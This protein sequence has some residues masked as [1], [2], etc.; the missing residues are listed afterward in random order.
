[1]LFKGINDA[2]IVDLIKNLKIKDI[3]I[4]EI[5][6]TLLAKFVVKMDTTIVIGDLTYKFNPPT[7]GQIVP[8]KFTKDAYGE[9]EVDKA[10]FIDLK[11][12]V[13]EETTIAVTTK[14]KTNTGSAMLVV[15]VTDD[16]G[17]IVGN[18]TIELEESQVKVSIENGKIMLNTQEV[19]VLEANTIITSGDA[20][21]TY[22]IEDSDLG[23]SGT[24][25]KSITI[26]FEYDLKDAAEGLWGLAADALGNIND[27]LLK[28]IRDIVKELNNVLDK[29]NN[30]E[31]VVNN[32]IDGYLDKVRD[33]LD[34]INNKTVGFINSINNR[35]QP[36]MVVSD[37]KGIKRLSGSKNYPT[38]V[39][40]TVTLYPTTQTMELLVPVARKHVAV[41]NVFKGN[42][43]AQG[44]D[45]DCEACLKAAN[46]GQLNKVL[47]GNVRQ[48][49]LQGLK[50]G[51]VYEIAY[52]G[53]DFHGNI[54]TRKYYVTVK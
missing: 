13:V 43:S 12:D 31:G 21:G 14:G 20:N 37:A 51:Y 24:Y 32:T 22:A 46:N 47:D 1:F 2:A 11:K 5:D 4:P 26:V 19:A 9:L 49:N 33:Y 29:I 53:L 16:N 50:S 17:N 36:F 23:D 52:S 25:T 6:S 28:Q 40:S 27:D 54:A 30:Y 10:L 7:E 3:E 39:K 45:D 8:V 15:P 34:K 44:G 48:I 38:V 42:E 35:F 18:A 41:T